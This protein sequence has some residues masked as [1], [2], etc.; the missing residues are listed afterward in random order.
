LAL[1]KTRDDGFPNDIEVDV[2]VAVGDPVQ[3]P[4]MLFQAIAGCSAAKS[5]YSFSSFVAASPMT[6]KFK[7]TA[8]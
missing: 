1:G 7:M 4:L 2:E 8:C 3:H 5:G 6:N